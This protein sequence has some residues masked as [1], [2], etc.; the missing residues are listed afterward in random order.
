MASSENSK[1]S[2]LGD[3]VYEYSGHRS[4]LPNVVAAMRPPGVLSVVAAA[5]E[6]LVKGTG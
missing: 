6:V 1:N 2:C 5:E 3:D 4:T